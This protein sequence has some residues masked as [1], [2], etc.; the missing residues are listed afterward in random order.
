MTEKE[1][2]SIHD[3]SEDDFD[4]FDSDKKK[5]ALEDERYG[6]NKEEGTTKA[7]KRG[8]NDVEGYKE[9]EEGED[10]GSLAGRMRWPGRGG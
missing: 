2:L 6:R 8:R 3:D 4:L 9:L 7:M 10:N 1:I 5:G